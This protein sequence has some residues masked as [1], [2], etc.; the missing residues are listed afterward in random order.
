ME[1]RYLIRCP[2]CG[3]I[4]GTLPENNYERDTGPET[5]DEEIETEEFE[6]QGHPITKVRCPKCGAWLDAD[7]LEAA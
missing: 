3:P 2:N 6:T 1:E 5:S 7:E 4:E